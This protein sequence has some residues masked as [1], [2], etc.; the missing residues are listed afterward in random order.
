MID[1]IESLK[2]CACVTEFGVDPSAR[3]DPVPL[4]DPLYM[5]ILLLVLIR[6]IQYVDPAACV[7][8]LL[9]LIRSI[10]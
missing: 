9:V 1:K 7:V 6:S 4:V 2:S 3:D 5:L 10:C 8:L